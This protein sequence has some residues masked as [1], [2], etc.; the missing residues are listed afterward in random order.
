MTELP[1]P[2]PLLSSHA[3]ASRLDLDRSSAEELMR[4]GYFG[5]LFSINERLAVETAGVVAAEAV[6]MIDLGDTDLPPALVVKVKAARREPD[7]D[8]EWIGWH[9]AL[10]PAEQV[11]G[12]R[13]WWAVRD[14]AQWGRRAPRRHDQRVRASV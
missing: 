8:R 13:S 6:P 2:R 11:D 4:A 5:E 9:A 3:I 10:S 14:P 12:V 1:D 7:G